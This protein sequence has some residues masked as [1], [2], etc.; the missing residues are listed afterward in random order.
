MFEEQGSVLLAVPASLIPVILNQIYFCE[1]IWYNVHALIE[2]LKMNMLYSAEKN[3]LPLESTSS[4][5]HELSQGP[6]VYTL[7]TYHQVERMFMRHRFWNGLIVPVRLLFD[8]T[9]RNS[10]V[11]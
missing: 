1:Q 5:E 10:S 7:H 4:L 2:E 11:R 9:L 8:A 6:H 3:L